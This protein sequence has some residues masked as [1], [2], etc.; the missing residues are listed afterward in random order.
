MN[1]LVLG[2]KGMLGNDLA[3]RLAAHHDVTGKDIE[4]FD[5]TSESSCRDIISDASFDVVVNAAAYTDVDGCESNKEQCFSVNAEGVKNVASVCQERGIKVVHFSTDYV[6]DGRKNTPY[7]EDDVCNPLNM[8][9]CAKLM[10]EQNLREMTTNYIL[11][12]SSWLFGRIGKNFVKTIVEKGRSENYIEV[13]DDQIGSPTFT[14]DLAAAIQ[15]LIEGHHT[16]IF[17]VTNRGSC[18]WYAFASKILKFTGMTDVNIVPIKS[19]QLA[20]P[21]VRRHFRVVGC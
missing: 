3:V 15:L 14:W 2:Y 16:G 8:Y 19:D 7:I 13:V 12:R 1:I 10:G 11:V 9:G 5:I 18:S 4:D 6:F 21:D 20:R 17:H